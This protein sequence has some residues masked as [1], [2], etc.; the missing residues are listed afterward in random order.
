MDKIILQIPAKPEYAFVLRLTTAAVASQIN[1]SIEDIE[2]LRVAV[3][4]ALNKFL[5]CDFVTINMTIESSRIEVQMLVNQSVAMDKKDM[6][7]LI[8]SSLMDEVSMEEK[9]IV[10]VKKLKD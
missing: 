8:L 2:D 5:L 4:E 1:A 10:L 7:A 3:S 6:G 9:S